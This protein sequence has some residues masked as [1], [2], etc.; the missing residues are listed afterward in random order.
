MPFA[1]DITST[2]NGTLA[3]SVVA[4]ILY[5]FMQAGDP[6]W[7]RTA[8]KTA[9]VLL[10]AVLSLVQG[11]PWLL[12][13]GLLASA[14][15][16]AALAQEG[17]RP[18]LAGLAA[19]LLAH[20]LY[21]VLFIVH[22]PGADSFFAEPWRAAAALV[23]VVFCGLMLRRLLPALPGE[24][25]LPVV[26]YVAAITL[27]GLTAFGVPGIGVAAGATL[28]VASDAILATQKFLLAEAS[29]HRAWTGHAVW[30]LYYA[31]QLLI[32]LAF[33]L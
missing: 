16:D 30:A 13:A 10:L 25:R 9:P 22:W 19:F 3:L 4:A 33:L 6:S 7:R 28:F 5:A 12:A 8:V 24:M 32:A 17:E 11:G 26:A 14:A 18:F 20:L 1:G 27:M 23:L 15:G 21:I 29:P 2:A 31:A